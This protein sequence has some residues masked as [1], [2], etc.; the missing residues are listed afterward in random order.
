LSKVNLA[1]LDR[2]MQSDFPFFEY[3]ENVGFK[4]AHKRTSDPV[5]VIAGEF[6]IKA[7]DPA[8]QTVMLRR[9][10][11]TKFDKWLTHTWIHAKQE[12]ELLPLERQ[13]QTYMRNAAH[14]VKAVFVDR[15]TKAEIG[16]LSMLYLLESNSYIPGVGGMLMRYRWDYVL[17]KNVEDCPVYYLEK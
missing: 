12:Y 16:K 5:Y 9:F 7:Q 2:M 11:P 3:V 8:R 6:N 10:D 13:V 14:G 1:K 15:L 4:I 17:K